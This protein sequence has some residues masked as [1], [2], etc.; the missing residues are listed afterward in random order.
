MSPFELCRRGSFHLP[1]LMGPVLNSLKQYQDCV[2]M[3]AGQRILFCVST[4]YICRSG[5]VICGRNRK[6]YCCGSLIPVAY[7]R[8]IKFGASFSRVTRFQISTPHFI[9]TLHISW[10]TIVWKCNG[11]PC[12]HKVAAV[13]RL[14]INGCR[15]W[16]R[17]EAFE[18][19]E[20]LSGGSCFLHRCHRLGNVSVRHSL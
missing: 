5:L 9:F 20:A 18:H 14:H 13:S 10:L 12:K 4:S 2:P 16:M 1:W 15:D 17:T 7:L 3:W 6:K 11:N 19:A 8:H